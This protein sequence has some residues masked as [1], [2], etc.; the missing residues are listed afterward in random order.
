M[1]AVL[2]APSARPLFAGATAVATAGALI[3]APPIAAALG[4][5]QAAAVLLSA[6]LLLG[7]SIPVLSFR[8]ARLR[9]PALPTGADDLGEDIDPVPAGPLLN[10]VARTDLFMTALSTALGAI[11]ALCLVPLA[12]APGWAPTALALVACTVLLLRSRVLLSAWQRMAMIVPA[13]L[14]LLVL[15]F[16]CA[17]A[18]SFQQ[19][20]AFEVGALLAFAACLLA[21]SRALP[22][23]RVLPYWGRAADL[24]ETL[25][26]LGLI[27]LVFQV[28]GLYAYVRG[29][30][31]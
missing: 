18:L 9:T 20:L 27:P 11:C 21:A 24:A 15:A 4:P 6:A 10:Q 19:R 8:L 29:L 25:T 5:A 17:Q 3:S 2:L 13:V 22:G 14:G 23:R 26:A 7:P 30:T 1:T 12:A 28:L 16:H 31:G